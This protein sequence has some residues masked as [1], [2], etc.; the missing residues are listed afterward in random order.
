MGMFWFF[1]PPHVYT[2]PTSGPVVGVHWVLRCSV[3]LPYTPLH[4]FFFTKPKDDLEKH[5]LFWE[6]VS[7][8]HSKNELK[9]P[10]AAECSGAL[11]KYDSRDGVVPWSLLPV[12]CVSVEMWGFTSMTVKQFCSHSLING[13]KQCSSIELLLKYQQCWIM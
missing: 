13:N 12:L 2:R 10:E 7:C 6:D 1:F 3:T 5:S 8:I 4:K 11:Q 9:Q